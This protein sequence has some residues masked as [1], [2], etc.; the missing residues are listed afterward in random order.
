M[1]SSIWVVGDGISQ[2][3]RNVAPPTMTAMISNKMRRE[4]IFMVSRLQ[5][6]GSICAKISM[7]SP[8]QDA[9]Q[10]RT[11][12]ALAMNSACDFS[13]PVPRTFSL[14]FQFGDIKAV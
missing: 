11:D 5:C 13:N 3:T 7:R 14:T 2:V 12:L 10:S 8:V 1:V 9:R 6:V 4:I